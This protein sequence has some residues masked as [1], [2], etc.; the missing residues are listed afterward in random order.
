MDIK[1]GESKNCFVIC[2]IGDK[3]SPTREWSDLIF[4]WII[5]P[6]TEKIGYKTF[7]ASDLAEPGII[8]SQIVQNLID[9]DL[10]IADLTFGNPNVFYELA[11]R[12]VTK[13]P[14]IHMIRSGDRIP[15]DIASNRTISLGTDIRTGQLAKEELEKQILSIR[16]GGMKWIIP[17]EMQ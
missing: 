11:I 3:D 2:P 9:A 14:C 15:F 8:T 5:K 7:R 6:V 1:S 12:H 16:D 4:E 17:L 13:K 10:V